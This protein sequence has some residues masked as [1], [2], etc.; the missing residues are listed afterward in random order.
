MEEAEDLLT[1]VMVYQKGP[2]FNPCVMTDD[3]LTN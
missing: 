1:D 3:W 2:K